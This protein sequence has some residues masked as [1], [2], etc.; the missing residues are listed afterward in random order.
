[1]AALMLIAVPFLAVTMATTGCVRNSVA[2]LAELASRRSWGAMSATLGVLILFSIMISVAVFAVLS[3]GFWAAYLFLRSLIGRDVDILV[4]GGHGGPWSC[5]ES[6]LCGCDFVVNI[7]VVDNSK[8]GSRKRSRIVGAREG[9]DSDI[10]GNDRKENRE[11]DA[12]WDSGS[13]E[14]MIVCWA[15][16]DTAKQSNVVERGGLYCRRWGESQ[17]TSKGS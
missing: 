5:G 13:R 12:K 11:D 15:I 2:A 10:S 6:I 16:L 8:K 1:M 14:R 3:F 9:V 17:L 7:A 4:L